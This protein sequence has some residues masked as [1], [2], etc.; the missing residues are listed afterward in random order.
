MGPRPDV[1][2][3]PLESRSET[4]ILICYDGSDDAKAA[5]KRLGALLPGVSATVLTVW[6][7]FSDAASASPKGRLSPLAVITN[8]GDAN[9]KMLAEA[10]DIASEGAQLANE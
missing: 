10:R 8:V 6:E 3:Y 4:V 9:D 2:P 7:S 5:I 1:D